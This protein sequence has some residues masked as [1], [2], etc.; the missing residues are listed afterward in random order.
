MCVGQEGSRIRVVF[1]IFQISKT[2]FYLGQGISYLMSRLIDNP[3]PQKFTPLYI[4]SCDD[5]FDI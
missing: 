3:H 2:T 5:I 1:Q 4:F